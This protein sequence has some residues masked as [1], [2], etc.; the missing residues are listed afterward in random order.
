[1]LGSRRSRRTRRGSVVVGGRR[2]VGRRSRRR[3]MTWALTRLLLLLL[4]RRL[5]LGRIACEVLLRRRRGTRQIRRGGTGDHGRILTSCARRLSVVH[6]RGHVSSRV[7]SRGGTRGRILLLVEGVGV[8]HEVVSVSCV[9]V[10][11]LHL[12]LWKRMLGA[13][14]CCCAGRGTIATCDGAG[15]AL[16]HEA[17]AR[18]RR[19]RARRGQREPARRGRD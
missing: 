16:E 4:R 3:L 5:R 14:A 1:M 12:M 10:H 7:P 17:E 19:G 9:N 8:F 2:I 13:G 15:G 6:G 18:E 11:A